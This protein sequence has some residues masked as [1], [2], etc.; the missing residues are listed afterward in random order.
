MAIRVAPNNMPEQMVPQEPMEEQMLPEE[1]MP[2]EESMPQ[3]E[4][5]LPIEKEMIMKAQELLISA[6]TLL[7]EVCPPDQYGQDPMGEQPMEEEVPMEEPV[8]P[9]E[10]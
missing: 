10:A 6:I 4:G 9:P 8:G 5:F 7:Q 2:Q 1:P 3:G